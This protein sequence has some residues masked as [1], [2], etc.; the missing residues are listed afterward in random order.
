M[1]QNLESGIPFSLI[2]LRDNPGLLHIPPNWRKSFPLSLK[3]LNRSFS[4]PSPLALKFERRPFG[5]CSYTL[6]LQRG[7]LYYSPHIFS[8][9]VAH[10]SDCPYMKTLN[11][12][13]IVCTCYI[14]TLSIGHL[15][16]ICVRFSA[17]S[18][19]FIFQ[20]STLPKK[21]LRTG[22]SLCYVVMPK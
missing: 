7:L 14:V 13:Q 22:H 9:N 17:H 10:S 2:R 20:Y 19:P 15:K 11:L 8:R 21:F 12:T 4:C 1:F 6:P 5:P 18:V 16:G 3:A